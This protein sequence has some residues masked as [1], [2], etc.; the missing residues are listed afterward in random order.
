MDVVITRIGLSKI[1]AASMESPLIIK[2]FAVG[3]AGGTEVVLDDNATALQ[4]ERYRDLI[5]SKYANKNNLVVECVL[6]GNAPIPVGFYLRELGIFDTQGDLI[7]IAKLPEQFRPPF[8]GNEIVTE[9]IFNINL[10]I[11]NT[12]NI[13]VFLEEKSFATVDSVQRLLAR[14]EALENTNEGLKKSKVGIDTWFNTNNKHKGVKVLTVGIHTWLLMEEGHIAK[15][16]D[17]PLMFK[18]CG[19]VDKGDGTFQV[20]F[21]KDGTIRHI[22]SSDSRALGSY[23]EDAMQKMTGTI[24]A[25]IQVYNPGNNS[26]TGVKTGVFKKGYRVRQNGFAGGAYQANYGQY[27]Y[28]FDNSQQVR[29]D[30]ENRMKNTA[31]QWY[32]LAKMEI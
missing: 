21:M 6:R 16:S 24:D 20:P 3:D 31:G 26:L 10:K 22:P 23:Q 27:H 29:T 11:E 7:A 28:D 8:G 14:V 32:M 19:A 13:E 30:T 17:Y 18:N 25:E 12:N 2:E 4:N 5:N 9:S 1:A 15:I